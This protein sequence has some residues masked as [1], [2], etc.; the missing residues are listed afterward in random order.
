[1][2]RTM[3]GLRVVLSGGGS[4][5]HLVP[6]LELARALLSEGHSVQLLR[7]G[8]AVETRVLEAYPG[9]AHRTIPMPPGKLRLP[10]TLTRATL[11]ARRALQDFEA[12]VVVGLGGR[13]ALPAV[14]AARSLGTPVALL[15][16]N[17]V[18][19]KANRLLARLASRSYLAFEE[20][21]ASLPRRGRERGLVT[22]MPLRPEILRSRSTTERSALL[23]D[24][25][26][27]AANGVERDTRRT[28]LL[29]GGSQGARTLNQKLPELLASL[30]SELRGTWRFV[31]LSGPDREGEA[32]DAWRR[33]GLSA[34]VL[35]YSSRMGDLIALADLVIGRGGAMTLLELAAAGR[36]SVIVPYPWHRDDHQGRNAEWFVERGAARMIRESELDTEL[37]KQRIGELMASDELRSAMGAN[38]RELSRPRAVT[39]IVE[40]LARLVETS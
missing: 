37:A 6:G 10:L 26:L 31:H 5:G 22:G 8:R 24:F 3:T 35:G 4:G 2:R 25:E 36:A 9:L 28:L 15:E 19:G 12:Q 23:R 34:T 39:H 38:A 16:Q 13:G 7:P 20:T 18:P 40:D 17:L 27:D 21:R 32:R 14:L 29:C 33:A 1:M 30:P 11:S